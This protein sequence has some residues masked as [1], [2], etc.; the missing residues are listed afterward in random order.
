VISS[1]GN[2]NEIFTP[3]S[4]AS[5]CTSSTQSAVFEKSNAAASN[6]LPGV[7]PRQREQRLDQFA[8]P[9][10]RALAGLDGFVCIRRGRA[11]GSARSAFA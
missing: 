1:G 3:R 11:R 4:S 10:R 7:E 8:H 6:F 9:L 2:S 5:G